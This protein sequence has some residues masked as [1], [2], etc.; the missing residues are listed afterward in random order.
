MRGEVGEP[1]T[2]AKVEGPP[3]NWFGLRIIDLDTGRE[4]DAVIEVNTV[5]G[6]CVHYLRGADGKFYL[7]SSDKVAT[8]RLVGRF[9]IR[10]P[11]HRRRE[12]RT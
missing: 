6:W 2:Y 3:N 1:I 8:E 4:V 5:E 12:R 10:P 7:D 11:R 9:E